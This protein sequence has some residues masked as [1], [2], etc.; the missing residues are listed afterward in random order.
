MRQDIDIRTT[1]NEAAKSGL[2]LGLFTGVFI[3]AGMLTGALASGGFGS[4][5]AGSL[6]SVVLWL[7]KFVGCLWLLRFFMLKFAGKYPELT[8]RSSF[9]FGRLTAMTSAIIVAGLNLINMT[10]VSPES[11]SQL[12]D[13][14]MQ[15][16][17]ATMPLSDSDRVSLEHVMTY[18][19]H[20]SFFVTLFYCFI[21]G[22]VAA[23]IFSSSIPP[24]DVFGD[25]EDR[26][27]D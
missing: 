21:Y 1:W 18:L 2:L 4:R 14:Y 25:V 23:R 22:T 15:T 10:I 12:I 7:A 16:Y 13:T 27:D 26:Q 17:S 5:L 19:P 20:I 11:V 8:A 9:R 24:R 3:Y 6:I